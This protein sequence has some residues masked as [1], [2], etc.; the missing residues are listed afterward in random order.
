MAIYAASA[1]AT[2]V[3]ISVS[4]YPDTPLEAVLSSAALWIF[5]P[6]FAAAGV[7]VV[8]GRRDALALGITVAALVLSGFSF[9]H[10]DQVWLVFATVILALLLLTTSLT[11]AYLY[12]VLA[13]EPDDAGAP[14]LAR[15]AISLAA[16]VMLSL[17]M[18]VT[19]ARGFVFLGD[20][21]FDFKMRLVGAVVAL[22]GLALLWLASRVA[23]PKLRL[24][25]CA[26]PFLLIVAGSS[27]LLWLPPPASG[28]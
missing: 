8:S 10:G 9:Q 28:L 2:V 25:L 1:G 3:L 13:G 22:L 18:L 19:H 6:L 27:A 24:T 20:F 17:S 26:E 16:S 5:F 7:L 4:R 15:A 11:Y 21:D 14:P 12:R 23:H